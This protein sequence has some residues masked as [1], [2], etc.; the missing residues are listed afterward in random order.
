MRIQAPEE[1]KGVCSALEL[2]TVSLGQW[3]TAFL[4]P[5]ANYLPAVLGSSAWVPSDLNNGH[6]DAFFATLAAL[7]MLTMP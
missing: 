1:M 2:V 4:I 3:M 5:V 7:G 6:L